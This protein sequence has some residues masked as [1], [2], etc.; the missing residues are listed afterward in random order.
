MN[1]QSNTG[2][3]VNAGYHRERGEYKKDSYKPVKNDFQ[4]YEKA[5]ELS[6]Y[7]M[8]IAARK[9]M[10]AWRFTFCN[11]MIDT[12]LDILKCIGIANSLEVHSPRR[13]KLQSEAI[14]LCDFFN[15]MAELL[16]QANAINEHTLG[17]WTK[18]CCDVKYMCM[19]WHK[20]ENQ[21]K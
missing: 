18:K 15:T 5:K 20:R 1:E 16:C 21:K 19:A 10:K 8:Q 12:T 2:G 14:K 11:R 13:E 17:V 6:K 4:L 3:A 7:T 9:R